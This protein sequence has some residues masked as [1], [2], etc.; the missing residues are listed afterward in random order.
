MD[1][2]IIFSLPIIVSLQH[3]IIESEFGGIEIEAHNFI[4]IRGMDVE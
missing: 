2:P 1:S 3:S 4:G